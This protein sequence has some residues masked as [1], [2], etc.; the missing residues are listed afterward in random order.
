MTARTLSPTEV[1]EAERILARCSQQG[2][3]SWYWYKMKYFKD[4]SLQSFPDAIH[5]LSFYMRQY[6]G[7]NT[8]DGQRVVW[9]N[10][11]PKAH[12]VPYNWKVMEVEVEDGGKAY[13]NIY[14]NLDT[15]Q[16]FNFLRNSIGG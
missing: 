12:S 10:A 16:C 15:K 7:L 1:E 4:S 6:K 5:P 3:M 11:F 8:A 9:I 14:V 13:F 2:R